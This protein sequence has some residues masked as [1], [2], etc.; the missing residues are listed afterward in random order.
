MT[1]RAP[2][3]WAGALGVAVLTI[4]A[5]LVFQDNIVRFLISPKTPF[6]ISAPPPAPEYGARGAWALWPD[7]DADQGVADIFYVHS[8]THY[9]YKSWNAAINDAAAN[10]ILKD[11]AA[12][13]EA[14]PFVG[15]GPIYGP[16][17]RQA[18][19]FAFFTHKFDGVAARQLA[20]RDVRRAFR[21][22]LSEIDD[23]RPIILVGYGQGGLHVVR[24]LEEFFQKDRKLRARLAVAYIIDQATPTRL[25]DGLLKETP[26]CDDPEAIRCV[27]SYVDY[28]PRFD[29]EME[30]VRRRSMTWS[31]DGDLVAAAGDELLC[32]NPLSWTRTAAHISADRN[33]GAA[34]A[35][36]IRFGAT[37][38][39][40][41]HAVGAKCVNGI[42]MVD[43]PVQEYLRRRAWFGAKWR[44][45]NFNLFYF[46]LATDARRRALAAAA[47]LK[48]ESR[49]LDPIEHTID[50]RESP[51]N[52]AP[53][54]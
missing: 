43:R 46:D 35:T 40:V 22:F 2:T 30:R 21:K 27:V 42:L 9:S 51:I 33:I 26:P 48:E 7:R 16:R 10:Q 19:L 52:K 49:Y 41:T 44:A 34:S 54:P 45:Q 50:L 6:Q 36:G 4:I 12:P 39:S 37:P 14:G 29:E 3:I 15:L 24:L 18:T 11:T 5:A 25:F 1:L 38:P 8:T 17:Y 32:V 28:E 53:K 20:Y 47:K 31:A 13:N 23:K